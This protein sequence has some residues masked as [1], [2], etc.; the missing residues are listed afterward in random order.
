MA[1]VVR[2]HICDLGQVGIHPEGFGG[3]VSDE[4]R[5]QGIVAA[6]VDEALEQVSH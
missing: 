2:T 1:T 5:G 4:G 3:F 6:H